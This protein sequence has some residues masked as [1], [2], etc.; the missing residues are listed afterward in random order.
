MIVKLLN[1]HHLEFLS[2]KGGFTCQ[3]ATLLE[4]TCHGSQST[5]FRLISDAIISGFSRTQVKIFC[6]RACTAIQWDSMSRVWSKAR[7]CLFVVFTA[8]KTGNSCG[9]LVKLIRCR[10]Q[11]WSV[12]YDVIHGISEKSKF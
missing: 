12:G 6:K 1:E 2:L 10:R 7:L 9:R 3:N 5:G 11:T 4:I 8:A